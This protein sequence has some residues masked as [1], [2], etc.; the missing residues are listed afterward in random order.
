M[1]SELN[2]EGGEGIMV[3]NNENRSTTGKICGCLAYIS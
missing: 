2:G 3:L 1:V